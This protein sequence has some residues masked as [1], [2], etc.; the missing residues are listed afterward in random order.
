MSATVVANNLYTRDSGMTTDENL[1]H[2]AEQ[3]GVACYAP[4]NTL[5]PR[6]VVALWCPLDPAALPGNSHARDS[7]Q[8]SMRISGIAQLP[9]PRMTGVGEPSGRPCDR[10]Y[11]S[12]TNGSLGLRSLNAYTAWR[13]AQ[14]SSTNMKSPCAA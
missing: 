12:P 2:Q 6:L 13:S 11:G 10:P 9:F 8:R 5:A 1:G 14:R 7:A 3:A 4:Y